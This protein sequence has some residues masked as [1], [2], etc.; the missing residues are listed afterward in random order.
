MTIANW[1]VLA[2]CMLP[3]LTIGL[4]K[5]NSAKLAPNAGRYDNTNPRE[6]AKGLSGWQ[7]RA[8]AAQNNGFEA[9]PLLSLQCYWHSSHT[10][11]RA[12][13]IP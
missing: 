5:A 8:S 12:V 4:A 13:S 7:Q 9:L 3:V 11:T 6:W 10:P 2:A 1:C